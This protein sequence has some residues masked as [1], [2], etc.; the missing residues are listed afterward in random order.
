MELILGEQEMIGRNVEETEDGQVIHHHDGSIIHDVVCYLKGTK[1]QHTIEE[2][3]L[4]KQKPKEVIPIRTQDK[5][6]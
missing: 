6:Q 3:D 5:F 1:N 2:H 4:E